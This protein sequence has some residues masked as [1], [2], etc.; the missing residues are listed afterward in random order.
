MRTCN[1][2]TNIIQ[3]S[4]LEPAIIVTLANLHVTIPIK[5][6]DISSSEFPNINNSQI[7]AV[8]I[9]QVLEPVDMGKGKVVPVVN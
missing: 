7:S 3:S 8:P 6:P 1:P 5:D 4:E 2:S 9:S